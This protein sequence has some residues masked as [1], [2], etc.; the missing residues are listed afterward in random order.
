[1]R[2]ISTIARYELKRLFRDWRLVAMVLSQPIII[3]LIVGLVAHHEPQH[4]KVL[5]NETESGKYSDMLIEELEVGDDLDV[6]RSDSFSNELISSGKARAVVQTS[7]E[8]KTYFSGKIDIKTDPSAG[9]AT[10]LAQKKISAAVTNVARA[11]AEENLKLYTANKQSSILEQL[12]MLPASAVVLNIDEKSYDPLEVSSRDGIDAE[13]KYFDYYGSS[14]MVV[15]VLL[16][17]LNLSGISI[18]SERASGTFERISVTPYRKIDIILGKAAALF[19]VGLVVNILGIATL[20]ALYGISL[21]NLWLLSL[22]S[23]L[24]VALAVNL[25]LL[26]SSVTKNLVESVEL[27]MYV[28]FVSFLLSGLLLPIESAQ[29]AYAFVTGVL[30]FYYSVS[31]SRKINMLN[32]GWS[33]IGWDLAII[34]TYALVFI[35]LAIIALRREAR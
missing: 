9:I 15:L 16:V 29:K 5:V 21:G 35:V 17:V 33:Q 12:P 7:F 10:I 30:P 11:M 25:G 2:N 27:S 22:S 8:Q 26:V 1:M 4:I 19:I 31:V 13:I 24:V 20:K 34:F 28:F 6:E 23:V 14:M 3:A 18:T 32:A